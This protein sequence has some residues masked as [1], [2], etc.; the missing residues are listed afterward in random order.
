MNDYRMY[1]Q[2]IARAGDARQTILN[3]SPAHASIIVATVFGATQRLIEILTS[4][5]RDDIY[6]TPEVIEAAV[7]FLTR[8]PEARIDIITVDGLLPANS[9]FLAAL[10]AHRVVND[11][12]FVGRCSEGQARVHGFRFLVGDGQHYRFQEDPTN[13]EAIVQFGRNETGRKLHE[14]FIALAENVE[15][16]PLNLL[17]LAPDQI[18]I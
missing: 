2:A 18:A 11:R 10:Q 9:R 3:R 7:T 14:I 15:R 8:N 13:T 16:I 17:P 6:G 1:V 5:L 4:N 12:V